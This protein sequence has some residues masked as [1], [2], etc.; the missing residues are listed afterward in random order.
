[1]SGI[2]LVF[3]HGFSTISAMRGVPYGRSS[4]TREAEWTLRPRKRLVASRWL[5]GKGPIR[6]RQCG[7]AHCRTPPS[8]PGC[9]PMPVVS[10]ATR[11]SIADARARSCP[12]R[13][14]V[15][16]FPF[17]GRVN[18]RLPYCTPVWVGHDLTTPAGIIG[19]VGR[20][21]IGAVVCRRLHRAGP[22]YSPTATLNTRTSASRSRSV[23]ST[24]LW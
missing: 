18:W 1:M 20:D 23:P 8:L 12:T 3:Q 21:D 7:R 5:S 24:L 13:T 2:S 16:A 9:E 14:C 11:V 19:V 22:C 15:Y 6:S 17:R 10:S 4:H